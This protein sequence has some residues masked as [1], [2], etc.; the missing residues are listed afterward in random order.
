MEEC[1]SRILLPD[2][3]LRVPAG[4]RFRFFDSSFHFGRGW[5]VFRKTSV[6]PVTVAFDP[7]EIASEEERRETQEDKT[8]DDD[9]TPIHVSR[10]A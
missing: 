6:R 1:D 8:P 2:A 7:D 10:F 4:L 3:T 9:H 5:F